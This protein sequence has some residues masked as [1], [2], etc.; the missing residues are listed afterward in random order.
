LPEPAPA[1]AG[2]GALLGKQVPSE[3]WLS[4]IE[5]VS[6]AGGDV[7]PGVAA[8]KEPRGCFAT[9]WRPFRS[10][11]MADRRVRLAVTPLTPTRFPRQKSPA[12]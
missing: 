9:G 7:N 10:R 2:Q 3:R 1:G 4:F 8:M 11:A 12:A 5:A 6:E